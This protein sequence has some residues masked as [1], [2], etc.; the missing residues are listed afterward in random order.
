VV[1]LLTTFLSVISE[2]AAF[3]AADALV[4]SSG[5]V[6]PGSAVS[7]NL[8]LTATTG[9]TPAALQWT[10][11]YPAS[12]IS[13]VT[14]TAGPSATAAGKSPT[15]ASNSGSY[16]CVLAGLNA[17]VMQNGVVAV[18]TFT[19]PLSF[20]TTSIGV[21]NVVAVSPGASAISAS[22]TGASIAAVTAGSSGFI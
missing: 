11:T 9:N 13:G 15:C 19:V 18:A 1:F 3:A 20:L 6:A 14:V 17:N 10:L 22:G 8:S 2:T 7:L 4:L 12:A 5:S 16:T 21:T